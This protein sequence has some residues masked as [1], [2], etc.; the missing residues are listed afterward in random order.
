MRKFWLLLF[1]FVPVYSL[2]AQVEKQQAWMDFYN[3]FRLGERWRYNSEI[4]LRLLL[5]EEKWTRY[6]IRNIF[7]YRASNLLSFSSGLNLHNL[8]HNFATKDYEIRPW[9]GIRISFPL[10]KSISLSNNLRF[11]ERIIFYRKEKNRL[12]GRFRYEIGTRFPIRGKSSQE[13]FYV[14]LSNEFIVTMKRQH[15]NYPLANRLNVGM[16][17]HFNSTVSAELGY[18]KQHAKSTDHDIF[19]GTDDIYRIKL[20]YK[21]D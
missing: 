19:L 16:G 5:N 6:N 8:Y 17:Y 10:S 7:I 3:E 21:W 18:V 9:Q 11:E 20:R 4:G 13:L 12:L 14:P 1:F 2:Q 15:G